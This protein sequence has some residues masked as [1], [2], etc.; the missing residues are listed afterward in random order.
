MK[1][2]AVAHRGVGSGRPSV[3]CVHTTEGRGTLSHRPLALPT[4]A[5]RRGSV[6]LTSVGAQGPVSLGAAELK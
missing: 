4:P 6:G 1:L 5:Q 3:L 2:R